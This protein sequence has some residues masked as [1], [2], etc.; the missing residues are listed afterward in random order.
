M[1]RIQL[2]HGV[3]CFV[4]ICSVALLAPGSAGD[5]PTGE[6]VS[7]D[8]VL[9]LTSPSEVMVAAALKKIESRWHPGVTVMVLEVVRFAKSARTVTDAI[10][11]LERKT[12]Q[13]FGRDLNAWYHWIGAQEYQSHPDYAKFKSRLYS[14]IDKRF[15]EYFE[16]AEKATI[17]LDEIRWGGVV[18]DGIPPLKNPKMIPVKKAT[19]L[20]AS[21]VVFGVALGGEYRCYPK[22]I[23]AWHEMFKDSIGT[24]PLCG[25]Y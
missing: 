24:T 14:R 19:Y 15:A 13:K 7:V 18:R 4:F 10:R 8:D 16:Q 20:A 6:F 9:R 12:G 5:E 17:R 22:R 3:H 23:L 21:D 25:A 2:F 1:K 11:L